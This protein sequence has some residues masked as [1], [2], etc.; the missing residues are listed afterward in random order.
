MNTEK[1]HS[2]N[3]IIFYNLMLI[4]FMLVNIRSQTLFLQ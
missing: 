3:K 4:A 2:E 1:E